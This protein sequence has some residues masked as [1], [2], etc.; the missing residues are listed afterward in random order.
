MGMAI[1]MLVASFC[2]YLAARLLLTAAPVLLAV[3]VAGIFTRLA[4][5]VY[6]YWRGG[7]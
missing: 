4:W 5:H 6:R 7:W 2:L 1:G 3:A